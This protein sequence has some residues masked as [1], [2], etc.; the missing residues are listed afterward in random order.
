MKVSTAIILAVSGCVLLFL[1]FLVIVAIGLG[2]V[3]G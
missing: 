2:S 3:W 1:I